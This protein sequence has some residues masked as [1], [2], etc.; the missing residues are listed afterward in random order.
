M[1]PEN[2]LAAIRFAVLIALVGVLASPVA[3][4]GG[5]GKD[6]YEQYVAE[7]RFYP[8]ER[9]TRYVR[10]IAA[11]L[12][13]HASD[14][15]R[16]YHFH[17]LDVDG[18][19]AMAT[20]DGYIFIHRG[21]FAFL[22]SE[23]QLAAVIGH[24]IGHVA[25]R[26]GRRHKTQRIAGKTLGVLAAI[27]TGRGELLYDVA[28]PLTALLTRGHGREAELEADRLGGE[29]MARA[30]YDPQAIIETVWALKDQQVFSREVAGEK[31]T[32][33]GVF[34]SHPRGDR[35]LHAAVAY[36]RGA[37]A[38]GYLAPVG[39]Y[40]KIID[41]LT[42]G[43]DAG[44]GL[45]KEHT[46]YHGGLRVVIEFPAGWK[47]RTPKMQVIAR[48]PGGNAE[49][50]ISIALHAYDEDTTPEEYV[51]DV[52]GRDDVQG[53]EMEVNGN[54]AFIGEVDTSESTV[55]LQ[56][57]AVVYHREKV[58]FFKSECGPQGDPD[59]LR[60]Q[61][62]ETL[63]KLRPMTADDLKIANQKRIKVIVAEPGL[64][65]A[66]LAADSAIKSHAEETLRLMNADYPYGE[67]TA[68]DYVKIVK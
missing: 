65:Y 58:F 24:E 53:K 51:F 67:P 18:V 35:R 5:L 7:N 23:A 2:N 50:T 39:D 33:H 11:R 55:R 10:D 46:Y 45:V 43:D 12:L 56:L 41:G 57:L 48:A 36:A 8:D 25:A 9:L 17:V 59:K 44:Q 13:P 63:E 15:G 6:L 62:L 14:R 37:S 4:A 20:P 61:F 21:L 54:P 47:V 34:A 31:P 28:D 27:A 3:Q 66:Q 64:T 22:N 68:G 42:F 19:N 52:L 30:G 40:W 38:E 29:Y 32:Y 1:G 26:H 60:A 49:G 16:D